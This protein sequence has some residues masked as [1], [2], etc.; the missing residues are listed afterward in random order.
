MISGNADSGVYIDASNTTVKGNLIGTNAA[1]TGAIRNGSVGSATGGVFI[2][3]GTGSVIGGM[4]AADRNVIAGNGGAG[5]WIEGTTGSHTIQGNYIGVDMT[6]DT[7]LANNRWGIVLNLGAIS[8]VQIGGTA[9]GA[10][11]V[12][13]GNEAS[14]GGVFIGGNAIGTVLE[15]NRIGVGATTNTALS[16]VQAVG[17]RIQASATNTRVGGTVAGA[18]NVIARNGSVGVTIIGN[19]SGT[20]IQGNAIYGNNGLA[21]DL[22]NDGITANDGAL[23]TGQPNQLMDKPVL[24]NANLVGS[25]LTLAGYVGSAA[26]QNTFANSRIEFYRTT[27]SSSVFLGALTTDV[28]GNF[29]GTLDVTGLGLTQSDPIIATATDPNGNTSEFSISFEAN[30]APTANSDSN[31]AVEAGG[32]LNASAGTNPS[33]NVLSNDTDQNVTDTKTVSGVAAGTVGTAVGSVGSSV[34]GTYGAIQIAAD[35]TY[36]YSVDHGNAAVQALRTSGDTLTDVFTYTMADSGG[37]TSTTQITITIQGANDNPIANVDN[38]TAIEA[39]GIANGTAGS[40]GTGN[41]LTNDTDVDSVGNGETKVVTGIVAGPSASAVGS[42][43]STVIGQYGSIVVNADGSYTYTIDDSNASVQALR[44]NAQTLDDVFTYTVI[45][46]GG[47]TST[48][49]VTITIRGRN[50]NPVGVNDTA[51]AV[52]AGGVANGTAGSSGTGNVLTNDTDVDSVGN[53][54]TKVVSGVAAGPSASAIGS[55][56]SSVTGTYG[57]I[58]IGSN[59]IYTY[60]VD[61]SNSAVQALRNTS[62]T[63]TDLFTYEVIDAGGLTSLATLTVTIQGAND[64]PIAN[65]DNGTAI[66]A[67]GIANGTAGS[68][69]TGNVLTND[70]DVDSVGNG[71]TKTVTGVVAGVQSS[72]IGFVSFAVNGQYG[73]IMV[74]ADGSYTYTIDDTNASVQALRNN[75]QTLDDVFTYTVTD[76]GGLTSTSQV[77]ITIR[78]RNDNPVGVNDTAIAVEAGGI[79]NGTSGSNGTG[80]VL[81]N[82]TM[83][84]LSEMVKRRL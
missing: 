82:D 52:E 15:G 76:A 25:N 10:G 30:A 59:G 41:V 73:S 4:T 74:N 13:A 54:E 6:G 53:G 20:T 29:S 1:G 12:I 32:A 31:T 34:S 64:N 35:G 58:T 71:E 18:G 69:G 44:T 22:G 68:T 14:T 66:E 16:S 79:G 5:I 21:I 36:S 40:T 27:S 8:N 70:T 11:N 46:A 50:D 63:L 49:Q 65:V 45:D 61:E 19:T 47:L 60:T 23:T 57:S 75:A 17:V 39:G 83:S 56:A 84:I 9:A 67:G 28:N 72:A 48:S 38:G 42:V 33:G 37:L 80:N 77:T 43:A 26:N 62:Q 55:V 51:T 2:A 24:S 3:S 78:G 7:A 81:T